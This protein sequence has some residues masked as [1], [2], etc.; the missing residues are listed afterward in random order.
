MVMAHQSVEHYSEQFAAKL[1]RY[2]YTTPKN[3]LDYINTYLNI[4]EKK[5]KENKNQQDRLLVG[6]DKIKEAEVQ[7]KK[8][9]EDL[10]VQKVKVT[11]R[12][13]EV[14]S[15]LKEIASGTAEASEKKELAIIKS[16]E[17]KEQTKV[18]DKEKGEAE[19]ALAEAL[20]A[21]EAAKL[22][23]EDLEKKDITEIRA[24]KN[25][26]HAVEQVLNC[27][28]IFK[29]IKEISWK[30]AQ[31]L[32]ADTGFLEMLKKMDVDNITNRQVQAVK[33][34]VS[35]LEKD[36]DTATDAQTQKD[37]DYFFNK[38]KSVSKAGAGL[39]KFVYAVLGY[40]SVFREVKPKKDK[41]ARLEKEYHDSTRE[42][43]KINNQVAKIEALLADLAK[44]L[45][46]Q[47]AEKTKLEQ[48]TAIMERR[49]I[50]ADKLINGL[51]SEN[52]RWSED[53]N[54]L[55]IKRVK[56]LGDCLVCAAFLAYV[57]AFTWEFR[58][59]L[60]FETWQ[61][62]L[63]EKKVPLSQPFRLED[64]LTSDVEISR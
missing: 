51:S 27:I 23:L 5:D 48:E 24:F 38:M 46:V 61:K 39:L 34:M 2:N 59:E 60:I 56:L 42:L 62:D 20:P 53:L 33:D 30:S 17:I 28:V 4:L 15:L 3:Y 49:L 18:I 41:V 1:R 37:Q 32:M 8:L 29:G 57:G 54:E 31:S 9:N 6:I 58:R 35:G 40:N 16:N 10:A 63:V 45:E 44:K 11:K 43:E 26:P 47:L 36:L 25:P 22:A 64:L 21:L 52:K 12:T 14:E 50:A 55:K 7:L 19:V 13:E